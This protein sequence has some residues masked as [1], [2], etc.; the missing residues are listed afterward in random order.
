MF[1]I[2]FILNMF[3]SYRILCKPLFDCQFS[4]FYSVF[5]S[6]Y[7]TFLN[8]HPKGAANS[9]II[10]VIVLAIIRGSVHRKVFLKPRLWLV[11]WL[12]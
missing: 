4:A 2:I 11:F 6:A 8:S 9:Y 3:L 12:F 10:K 5:E 7:Y 1:K